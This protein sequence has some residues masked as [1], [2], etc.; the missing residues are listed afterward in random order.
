MKKFTK[1]TSF[2]AVCL[3][4]VIV[5]ISLFGCQSNID[6]NKRRHINSINHRGYVDAPEN[7]LA[8]FRLSKEMGFNM[9]ECDVTFTMD[10]H[11]VLL[12]DSSVNRTSNGKGKISEMTLEQARLLDFG[13]WK[14][15]T[16]AGERIPTFEE[17]VELCVELELHPYVEIKSG[18]TLQQTRQLIE[19]VD[20]TDISVTWIGR[21][22]SVLT[23]ISQL[24]VGDR[25]GLLTEVIGSDDL[26]FL[27][28]LSQ[29][30]DI[31]VDCYYHTLTQP[32]IDRC[33]SLGIPL[34]VWTVNSVSAISNLHP[35]VTGVTSDYVN[36]QEVFNNL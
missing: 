31:F 30:A 2:V 21:N 28:K 1:T 26:L 15:E 17:F 29:T 27:T 6:A 12:H 35:Y 8:A 19:I 32:Q 10:D 4:L 13:S 20:K 11:P 25:I 33:R 5:C 22:R 14:S 16:Y 23:L 24:R 9:V 7:T 34:E 36:A 18:V 3:L